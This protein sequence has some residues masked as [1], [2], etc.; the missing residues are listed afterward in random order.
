MNRI[1]DEEVL[2]LA[3]V[4]S[5]AQGVF[6]LAEVSGIKAKVKTVMKHRRIDTV[7]VAGEENRR[8]AEEV[9][10]PSH[11][12]EAD[13]DSLPHIRSRR[14]EDL[15]SYFRGL[16]HTLEWVPAKDILRAGNDGRTRR[17]VLPFTTTER[18]KAKFAMMNK[19]VEIREKLERSDTPL[20]DLVFPAFLRLRHLVEALDNEEK[21]IE[22]LVGAA[23][24]SERPSALSEADCAA[25]AMLRNLVEHQG[26]TDALAPWVWNRLTREAGEKKETIHL[27]LDGEDY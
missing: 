4:T 21:L 26:I 3:Q 27:W 14:A 7:L 8:E 6:E 24:L 10:D 11:V 19:V 17:A 1:P 9:L 23:C 25:A 13:L 12:K 18:S 15:L 5:P 2:V 16:E 22:F 20:E